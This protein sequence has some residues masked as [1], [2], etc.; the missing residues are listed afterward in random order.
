[1][2]ECGAGRGGIRAQLE[3]ERGPSSL[4][5]RRI[6]LPARALE[7]A[8]Q[9]G[10]GF[11][12]LIRPIRSG[13]DLGQLLA[14]KRGERDGPAPEGGIRGGLERRQQASAA[15]RLSVKRRAGLVRRKRIGER[16]RSAEQEPF[17]ELGIRQLRTGPVAQLKE[18][19][20]DFLRGWL[21]E[22]VG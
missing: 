17:S 9:A 19:A 3:E 8:A 16:A 22:L 21:A 10:E 12:S 1:A 18:G 6:G 20:P 11:Q 2:G 5:G 7:R 14:G 15:S 13:G 4:H